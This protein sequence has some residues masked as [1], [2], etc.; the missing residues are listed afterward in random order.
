MLPKEHRLTTRY[1]YGKVRKD[2]IHVSAHFFHLYYLARYDSAE[3]TKVG[4]IISNKFSK[5]A[6][7][8]NRLKRVF[9]E[10]IRTNFGKIKSGYWIVVH[11]KFNVKDAKYEEINSD[12]I[13]TIQKSPF[14]KEF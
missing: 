3:D 5:S 13:K 8:R 12:F 14:S 4:I 9:R 2:G 7:V 1:E 11:P 6:P 10:V